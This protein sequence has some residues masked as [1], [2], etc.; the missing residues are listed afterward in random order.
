MMIAIGI[1]LMS[2][3]MIFRYIKD[4]QMDDLIRQA[5]QGHYSRRSRDTRKK[6]EQEKDKSKNSTSDIAVQSN[7]SQSKIID[8]IFT[9]D[10]ESDD[11]AT[12]KKTEHSERK[13]TAEN[14][15][16]TPLD[17][18]SKAKSPLNSS[19]HNLAGKIMIP[20]IN[21]NLPLFDDTSANSLSNGAGILP[22][23]SAPGDGIG[24]LS[25]I[26]GHRGY[27]GAFMFQKINQLE[28]GDRFT[29][30][31]RGGTYNYR[32]NGQRIVKPTDPNI[33]EI[34]PDKEVVTLLTCHPLN[35]SKYRLLVSGERV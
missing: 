2:S 6:D 27:Y 30:N 35:S 3:T 24:T 11:D 5:E 17:F 32:V 7:A 25:I 33:G 23:T 4:R 8:D 13:E 26:A 14:L 31:Y 19:N 12:N 29:I 28:S 20:K 10:V 22:D 21:I 15:E 18:I 34:K 16:T 1:L 9:T